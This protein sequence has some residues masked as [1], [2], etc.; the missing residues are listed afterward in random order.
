MSRDWYQTLML[1]STYA[2]RDLK[3]FSK[4]FDY[5]IAPISDDSLQRLLDSHGE[6]HA[7]FE[8]LSE[9]VFRV[10]LYKWLLLQLKGSE[11]DWLREKLHDV[12][13]TLSLSTQTEYSAHMRMLGI[14]T[15]WEDL[16]SSV[17]RAQS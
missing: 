10:R 16:V 14:P 8:S 5:E 17:L 2:V 3:E 4:A 6:T 15:L 12:L 9:L 11:H 1:R 13:C 7:F